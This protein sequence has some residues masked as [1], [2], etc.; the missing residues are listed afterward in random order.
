M[1]IVSDGQPLGSAGNRASGSDVT[2]EPVFRCLDLVRVIMLIVVSVDI[3]V[4]GVIS[5][6]SE[7]GLTAGRSSAAR[8][9]RAHV[10]GEKT[11]NVA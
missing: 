6:C 10:C 3:K 5:K 7:V 9:R 4:D 8:I 11:E 2:V 1:D